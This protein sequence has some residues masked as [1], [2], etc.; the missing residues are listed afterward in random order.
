M[1]GFLR[2]QIIQIGYGNITGTWVLRKNERLSRRREYI[3]VV[4]RKRRQHFFKHLFLVLAVR[5]IASHE[6][7]LDLASELSNAALDLRFGGRQGVGKRAHDDEPNVDIGASLV[8]VQ[9]PD[10]GLS[11][12]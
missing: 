12:S 10:E 8:F 3:T 9:S 11:I 4:L 7:C 2:R 6:C 1:F 5:G